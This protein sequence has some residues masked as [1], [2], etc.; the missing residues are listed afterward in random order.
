MRRETARETARRVRREIHR[1]GCTSRQRLSFSWAAA[2]STVLFLLIATPASA[3]P[4]GKGAEFPTRSI[5][6]VVGFPP[7]G[8]TDILA[9]LTG[10]HMSER[11]GQPVVIDNR[12][13]AGGNIGA[14]LAARANPD[15]Y[16]LMM[17]TAGVSG[18]NPT[19]Y[20]KL[21]WSPASFE[22]VVAVGQTPNVFVVNAGSPYKSLK[23]LTAV[24]RSSA[25]KVTF[26]APGIGTTG[27]LSGE[28]FKTMAGV[29]LTFVPFKGSANVLTDLLTN[30]GIALAVDNLPPYVP[31]IKAGRLRPLA[32]GTPKRSSI[33][34]DVPTVA[35]AGLPGY[36]S[37]AWFGLVAPRGTPKPVIDRI[38]AEVNRLLA[39]PE[40]Q[41]RLAEQ[42]IEAMGGSPADFNALIDSELK[43]WGEVVR[44]SGAKAE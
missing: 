14:E 19:L 25:A 4:T 32:V 38:N 33:L 2:P 44:K 40:T 39:M 30:S 29:D 1:D 7:A 6:V 36:L 11:W 35:E 26:G 22:A 24:A 31:Q 28:L 42:S 43:R 20:A 5:R 34:P 21:A 10:Q 16:T 8:T 23:E 9:R 17:T 18:I 41:A 15:G 13:G 27:H 3:Q 37:Y 12:P